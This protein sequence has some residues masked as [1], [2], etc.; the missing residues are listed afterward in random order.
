MPDRRSACGLRHPLVVILTL[1]ACA[2]LVVGSDSVAAIWQWA[3]RTSQQAL[4]WLGAC[5]D[6]FTGRFTVPSERTFRRVPADLDADALDAAISGYVTENSGRLRG[7]TSGEP[8]I[9]GARGVDATAI[10]GL[11]PV[12][13]H[14]D[15]R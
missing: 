4:Q 8:G 3:A 11:S 2:T 14:D 1:T 10:C 7:G 9:H 12:W 5:R 13:F 15:L 6:P